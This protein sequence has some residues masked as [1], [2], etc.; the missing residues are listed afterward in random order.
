M[1]CAVA[2]RLLIV[3]LAWPPVS[4]SVSVA[5]PSTKN[6]TCPVG[7]PPPGAAAD[8]VAAAEESLRVSRGFLR[9]PVLDAVLL[10][11]AHQRRADAGRV[12]AR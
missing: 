12:A 3:K 1:W 2:E 4:V 9:R 10:H 7:V 11:R 6:L 5:V 8:T